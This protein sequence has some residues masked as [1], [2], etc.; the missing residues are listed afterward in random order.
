MWLTSYWQSVSRASSLAAA[1][2]VHDDLP[3]EASHVS[4]VVARRRIGEG[5]NRVKAGF[6]SGNLRVSGQ[7]FFL[8]AAKTT[9]DACFPGPVGQ[10]RRYIGY[11]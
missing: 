4:S 8:A 3:R 9:S 5:P 7:I 1:I 6:R 11:R 2:H 10:I